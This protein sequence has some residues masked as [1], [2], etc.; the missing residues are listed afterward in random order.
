VATCLDAQN[1]PSLP[2]ITPREVEAAWMHVKDMLM[3]LID[4]TQ[5]LR[6]EVNALAFGVG[7]NSIQDTRHAQE[8]TSCS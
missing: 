7:H 5:R 2:G 4:E 6:R 8:V 1:V 3:V